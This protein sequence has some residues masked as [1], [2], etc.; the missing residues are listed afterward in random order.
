MA[1]PI[2]AV[3][4]GGAGRRMGTPKAGV[5]LG[6]RALITYPL[7]AARGAGLEAVVV[8]KA[9]TSLPPLEA[10]VWAEPAQPRHPLRGLVT[11]LERA[12]GRP[13]LALG[14][15]LPFVTSDLLAWLA[16]LPQCTAVPCVDGRLQP[17]LARYDP[18]AVGRLS[19]AL[20]DEQPLRQ[21]VEGLRPRPILEAQLRRFG[22]P[23]RLTFNVNTPADLA[24]AERLAGAQGPPTCG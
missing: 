23:A 12:D 3:L 2:V 17:L 24:E 5:E 16:R 19:A 22:A 9:D 4:A 8:A 20:T 14:C 6:G 1:T 18:G 13:V 10:T 7:G 11:A 21:A 15:D